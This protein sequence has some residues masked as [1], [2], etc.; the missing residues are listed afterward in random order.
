MQEDYV[1]PDILSQAGQYSMIPSQ[2]K[3]TKPQKT[4]KLPRPSKVC[5]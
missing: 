3:H 1:S 4:A 5:L 2:N